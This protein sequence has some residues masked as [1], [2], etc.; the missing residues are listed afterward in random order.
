MTIRHT[1]RTLGRLAQAVCR[2]VERTGDLRAHASNFQA[3]AR[4]SIASQ[5]YSD[6]PPPARVVVEYSGEEVD[7][8]IELADALEETFRGLAV[9]GVE[10]DD[11][12]GAFEVKTEDG[13]VLF[14]AELSGRYPRFR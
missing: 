9:E 1:V 10:L 13:R 3:V 5:F 12:L 14:S 11:R 8:F 4:R 7:R 2:E 6:K